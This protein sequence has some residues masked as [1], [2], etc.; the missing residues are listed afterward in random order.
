MAKD[1]EQKTDISE[2]ASHLWDTADELRA[3]SHLKAGEYS[4]PVL[5]LIFLKF[6]DSRFAEAETALA[7]KATRRRGIGKADY[8][9]RGVLYLPEP[10]RFSNLL[11]LPESE[12]LGKAIND[13]MVAI[14]EE[15]TQLAGVLPRTYQEFSNDTLVRLLRSVNSMLGNIEGDAFGKVYEYFLG[16]FAIAEGA[17]GGEYFTPT[18]IVRLIVPPQGPRSRTAPGPP[19]RRNR[20]TDHPRQPRRRPQNALQRADPRPRPPATRFPDGLRRSAARPSVFAAPRRRAPA[21]HQKRT[22][23][24]AEDQVSDIR[25]TARVPHTTR[26]PINVAVEQRGV[27]LAILVHEHELLAKSVLEIPQIAPR[28]LLDP[29]RRR[30]TITYTQEFILVHTDDHNR[31]HGGSQDPRERRLKRPSPLRPRPSGLGLR[32]DGRFASQPDR[33]S[34]LNRR[35]GVNSQPALTPTSRFRHSILRQP[36]DI[37]IT[38]TRAADVARQGPLRRSGRCDSAIGSRALLH[39]QVPALLSAPQSG[40]GFEVRRYWS[41]ARVRQPFRLDGP[42]RIVVVV[43]GAARAFPRRCP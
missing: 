17:K 33:G 37:S 27:N 19:E 24:L 6:A 7:G 31:R 18:S 34:I 39:P 36:R 25:Q 11:Q 20:L 30:M 13:A 43:D 28:P 1:T 23:F 5:G 41:D 40:L 22:L 16:K 9:S 42:R 21:R 4:L 15:N 2:V 8:Q 35:Y 38:R 12:N 26:L 32:D 14:E 10:A 3:N 29:R